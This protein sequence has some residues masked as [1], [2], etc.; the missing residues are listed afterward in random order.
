MISSSRTL[1]VV[2]YR[3][4]LLLPATTTTRLLVCTHPL[5]SSVHN[6]SY[7]SAEDKAARQKEKEKERAQKEKEK[8]R[9]E[10]EKEKEKAQK[11]KEKDK[12]QKQKE[13]DRALKEKEKQKSLKEKEKEKERVSKEKEKDRVSKEKEKAKALKEEKAQRPKRGKNAFMHYM[14]DKRASYVEKN[15]NASLIDIAKGLSQEYALLSPDF[16]QKYVDLAAQDRTRYLSETEAHKSKTPKPIKR[17][18]NAYIFYAEHMRDEIAK[19]NP[20]AKLA[21]ISKIIAE[22]YKALNTVDRMK[23]ERMAEEDKQRYLKETQK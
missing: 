5:A 10:K 22:Q 3:S 9:K 23:Y 1:S 4:S 7:S 18:K 8:E 15:P 16:K 13:K 12:A 19:N 20:D 21:D 6:R 11:E 2:G 17:A 14:S